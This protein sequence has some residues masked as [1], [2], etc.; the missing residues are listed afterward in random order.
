MTPRKTALSYLYI[1]VPIPGIVS[2]ILGY[3]LNQV[4]HIE[5]SIV[6]D[7]IG[8]KWSVTKKEHFYDT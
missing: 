8:K 4:R 6:F 5:N 3:I 7:N 2:M 1:V